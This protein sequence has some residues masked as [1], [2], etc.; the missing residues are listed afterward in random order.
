MLVSTCEEAGLYNNDLQK[1]AEQ[2]VLEK[3]KAEG[4]TVVE[5]LRLY[6]MSSVLRARNSTP[7]R[8]SKTGRRTSMIR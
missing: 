3:F 2:D 5:L 6:L 4:V 7:S 1:K 8:N